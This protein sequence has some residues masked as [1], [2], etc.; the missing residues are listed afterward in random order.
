MGTRTVAWQDGSVVFFRAVMDYALG[1][2]LNAGLPRPPGLRV[3]PDDRLAKNA[4]RITGFLDQ[5][6]GDRLSRRG[7]KV[8]CWPWRAGMRRG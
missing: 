2:Y 3:M 4:G 5:A 6:I 8:L 1:E 7:V